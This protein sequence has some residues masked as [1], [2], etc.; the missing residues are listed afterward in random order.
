VT[1][2]LRQSTASQEIPLGPFVDSTD[3][4]TAETALSIANTDIKL[5]KGGATS[6]TNKNS[7][8]ATHIATGD[9]YAVLDATDTDTLGALRVKVHVAGAL[10]VWLD[11]IVYPA[12]V[13]DALFAGSGNGIRADLR[14][15]LG[16]APNALQSGRVDSYV[17]AMADAVITAAK[18]A[19]GA[20][21]AVWTVATRTLTGFSTALAVS[22]WDVLESA[23][24]TASSMGVKLKTNL[25]ATVS[26][27]ST[28]TAADVWASG[29]RTLTSF[30]TL[31]ADIWNNGTR[32]LTGFSTALAVSVWDVLESAIATAS[33]IG[34]KVKT[35]LD[36][37]V[38][39]RS[40]YAGADTAGTTTLLGRLTAGRAV[41]LDNLD[42]TVSTRA[43]PAQ[44]N[45]EMVD[46]L[47]VDTYAEPGQGAP[48]ATASLATKINYLF[49]GW[50]NRKSQSATE[51]KL[52]NDDGVTVDQ[53]ATVSDD[54]T[55]LTVGEQASGP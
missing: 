40:T 37:T 14:T 38:S 46:A 10:P 48:P 41:N 12:E 3:G 47:N 26:S 55:T 32:T 36:A 4:N 15:W 17:G 25:D 2:P 23:V 51:Q 30:G 29:T 33:S 7:G 53:K 45:A 13:Y 5:Q 49:K 24:A 18:F 21:D 1:F 44:V 22:V 50:R 11:C 8:G 6:Q 9:Y 27:R 16:S 42:A 52:F 31:V 35:N 39:S 19:A 20:F 34:L 54:G 28:H 43:T